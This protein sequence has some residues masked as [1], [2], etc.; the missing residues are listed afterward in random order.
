MKRGKHVSEALASHSRCGSEYF[1]SMRDLFV[2]IIIEEQLSSY[3]CTGE[4]EKIN[5][6][7]LARRL[8]PSH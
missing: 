2:F 7:P 8:I 3:L 1:Q 5:Y 4:Q 6:T